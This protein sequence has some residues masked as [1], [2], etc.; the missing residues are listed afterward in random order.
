MTFKTIGSAGEINRDGFRQYFL[1]FIVYLHNSRSCIVRK[2]K[3]EKET[4]QFIGHELVCS[5]C[6]CVRARV[7]M[8]VCVRVCVWGYTCALDRKSDCVCN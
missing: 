5:V 6:V 3:H 7:C 8:R 4:M 1:C 2:K